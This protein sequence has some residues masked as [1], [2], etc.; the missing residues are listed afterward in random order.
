MRKLLTTAILLTLIFFLP[1]VQARGE[2]LR[3][4]GERIFLNQDTWIIKVSLDRQPPY[5]YLWLGVNNHYK[6]PKAKSTRMLVAFDCQRN[7]YRFEVGE[8]YSLP[9]NNG[10]KLSEETSPT[11]WIP[12]DPRT[13]FADFFKAFSTNRAYTRRYYKSI[14]SVAT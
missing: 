10:V 13:A 8:E 5:V 14:G 2:H 7:N 12:V 4:D 3:E 11:P 6:H 1:F 9:L